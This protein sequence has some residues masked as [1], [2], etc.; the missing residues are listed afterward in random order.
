MPDLAPRPLIERRPRGGADVLV[1]GVAEIYEADITERLGRHVRRAIEASDAGAFVLDLSAVRFL[2]S[3]ALGLL[4]NLRAQL[5]ERGYAFALAGATGEVA[6]I[7]DCTRL[8]EV[9]PV[10]A[11]VEQALRGLGVPPGCGG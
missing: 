6:Y 1:V 4:I 9:M 10:Y 3:G 7:L 2:T 5:A 11:T 8:A